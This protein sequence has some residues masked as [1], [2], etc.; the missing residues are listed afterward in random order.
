MRTLNIFIASLLI[1]LI[2]I[3]SVAKA[4]IPQ[5]DMTQLSEAE[6]ASACGGFTLPNGVDINVGIDNRLSINGVSVADAQFSLNGTTVH[7]A[8]SGV[9]HIQGP[10]GV[11][12][13]QLSALGNSIITNT[14][15]NLV[16]N[17]VRT[18][19]VDITNMSMQHLQAMHSLSTLGAQ[20]SIGLRNGL[21]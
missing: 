5:K 21:H 18:I 17:Q 12:N 2:S 10:N 20:A 4:D 11:T 13:V 3:A 19:T 9:T 15:N 16:L 8:S 1:A 14:A 6:L 7:T